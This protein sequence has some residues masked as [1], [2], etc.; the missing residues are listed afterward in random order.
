M[1]G[2]RDNPTHVMITGASSGIGRALALRY[3]APGRLL[4][5]IGRDADRLDAVAA[6]CRALGAEI[7]AAQ[8]D[9]TDH[10]TLEPWIESRDAAHPVDMVIAAAGLGGNRALAARGGENGAQARDLMSVN[11]LGVLNTVTPLQPRMARR[12][13]GHVVIVGSIQGGIGLP[14]SPVYSASKAAL[15][16]YADATRRLLRPQGVTVTLVLP[17]F[18]DTPMS[19]SLTTPRPWL[20]TPERAADRIARDVARGARISAFPWP[21]R[22]AVALGAI[23]PAPVVDRILTYSLRHTGLAPDD[24]PR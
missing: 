17:G 18:V 7:A 6:A 22:L 12:G 9:V 8:I 20:W 3:A 1:A 4:S 19:Q 16:I 24:L 11:T 2:R 10:A 21:L 23:A 15:K 13:A 5:L 14:Q